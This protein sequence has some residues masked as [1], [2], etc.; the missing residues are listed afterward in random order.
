[1]RLKTHCAL[2][3]PGL[4]A[5]SV[6][7]MLTLKSHMLILWMLLLC[8]ALL[9][10][11]VRSGSDILTSQDSME[12]ALV[13]LPQ[14][15]LEVVLHHALST[16]WTDGKTVMNF[17]NFFNNFI[18]QQPSLQ[19]SI[20][21]TLEADELLYDIFNKL[22]N[23][24][25]SLIREWLATNID[26]SHLEDILLTFGMLGGNEV[27]AVEQILGY[28]Y[29]HDI[30]AK[31]MWLQLSHIIDSPEED[32]KAKGNALFVKA[33]FLLFHFKIVASMCNGSPN[34]DET[35]KFCSRTF[36][37]AITMLVDAFLEYEQ[38]DSLA[39]LSLLHFSRAH[40]FRW[41]SVDAMGGISTRTSTATAT[42][43]L[44]KASINGSI[45]GARAMG[46]F[47]LHG[48]HGTKQSCRKAAKHLFKAASNHMSGVA[49]GL[50]PNLVEP[51]VMVREM[52]KDQEYLLQVQNIYD[53]D[54]MENSIM[55]SSLDPF[56]QLTDEGT[57][58][59]AMGEAYIQGATP[60]V[61][62]NI[63]AAVKEFEKAVE[64]GQ[65]D[66]MTRLG[67]LLIQGYDDNPPNLEAG[68]QLL[69]RAA[70]LDNPGALNALGYMY[71]E[72]QGVDQNDTKAFQLFVKASEVTNDYFADPLLHDGA[73]VDDLQDMGMY[74][75]VKINIAVLY[76]EGRGTIRN[77]TKAWNIFKE[78]ANYGYVNAAFNLGLLHY[79]GMHTP[80]IPH[81]FC[82]AA[83]RFEVIVD[84]ALQHQP[85][86]IADPMSTIHVVLS[87]SDM[88]SAFSA[89]STFAAAGNP[90]AMLNAAFLLR[91]FGV[92]NDNAK[93]TSP[94]FHDYDNNIIYDTQEFTMQDSKSSTSITNY[95]KNI[96][97]QDW[98]T[99]VASILE[100]TMAKDNDLFWPIS[101]DPNT[102]MNTFKDTEMFDEINGHFAERRW[103]YDAVTR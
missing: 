28:F 33:Q 3:L 55:H 20:D 31:E 43:A 10:C 78:A 62:Y 54:F 58:H 103:N 32:N 67:V 51:Q 56:S 95:F 82:I 85:C 59:Y 47:F 7:K 57:N 74:S 4:C 41:N 5:A 64:Q 92:R 16:L 88:G 48:L 8:A 26:S 11:I 61:P 18:K 34:V 53:P 75:E 30:T 52:W 93:V 69:N 90:A 83:G 39:L 77:V 24:P 46:H 42:R 37:Q 14:E 87:G 70:E 1:M 84:N 79:H 13:D 76:L 6:L 40:D 29:E 23:L 98:I 102:D 94:I 36:D 15:D 81:D 9:P 35:P 99:T 27:G 44:R 66:A 63:T 91:E 25:L 21:P 97:P 49:A 50:T 72:G 89:Y 38:Y 19:T 100:D 101:G 17:V 73:N 80:E 45:L 65:P 60:G 68:I 2:S 96:I 22:P 12:E 71:L 86:L